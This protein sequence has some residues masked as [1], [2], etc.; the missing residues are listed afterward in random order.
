MSATRLTAM[1]L[2][3]LF[4]RSI[5][6]LRVSVTDRCDFRCVYCGVVT[7]TF[8]PISDA[9]PT[10]DSL[11]PRS[12]LGAQHDVERPRTV[13]KRALD[14][15][16]DAAAAPV[17]NEEPTINDPLR[18]ARDFLIDTEATYPR[19]GCALHVGEVV[20]SVERKLKCQAV[21]SFGRRA[22]RA[23][24]GLNATTHCK[25]SPPMRRLTTL[26]GG[27]FP[28]RVSWIKFG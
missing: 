19:S 15:I 25:P 13:K 9:A 17:R 28:C 16:S 2:T 11:R 21:F 1:A 24:G 5:T 12:R 27:P 7:C 23:W 6:Y 20:P 22:R 18:T 4:G 14:D 8:A 3:D 26:P 10:T